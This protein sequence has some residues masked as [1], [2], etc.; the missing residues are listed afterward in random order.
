[1]A[2]TGKSTYSAGASLPEISEDVSDII[3]IVSPHETP[4]LDWLGD[5]RTEARSTVHEWLEDALLPNT[6]AIDDTTFSPSPTAATA[7][8]V[9]NAS[10]FRVGDQIAV[11]GSG[12]VMLVT[13]INDPEIT[14][15][16]GYG[17]TTPAALGDG[18][19]IIILGNA[20]LEGADKPAPRFTNRVRK[21][22]FTQIL[23]ASVE[24]SG[25]QLAANSI[26]IADEMDYQKQERL[27][28][29]LRDL[30]N[31]VIN[32]VAPVS[33]PQGGASVR[34]TM[35]G[36][37]H[38][39]GTNFF[40]PGING[41]PAGD[42]AGE[43]ELNEGVLNA[44]LRR[45]WEQS[46]GTI[47]TILVGGAQKRRINGF[48]TDRRGY[49][50]GDEKFRELVNVYESDFGVCRIVMSRWMP[51]GQV[52]LLDSSRISVLPLAG[53][54]FHFKKLA[55]SGDSESGQVI[56]EYTLQFMN[57]NAH[58]VIGGLAA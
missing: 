5:P 30:E 31:S 11:E 3:G 44:A 50:P 33:D 39:I 22:N 24:V 41:I 14:V 35:N 45:V 58:A 20:A 25:S 54:S 36:I 27:R 1:M 48:A 21:S 15:V 56:G 6:D 28:E 37:L 53:R 10:R 38:S 16:R 18:Q 43:N 42:G 19:K 57:E 9:A 34:R 2:F 51:P 7:F 23:T 17:G 46:A 4:L 47:D 32:G 49:A 26:G 12:E 52:A 8:D 40:L 29:L 13:A 55:S